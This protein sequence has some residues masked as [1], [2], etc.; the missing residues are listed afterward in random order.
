MRSSEEQT[1]LSPGDRTHPH[2]PPWEATLG[3]CPCPSPALGKGIFWF[4]LFLPC[5]LTEGFLMCSSWAGKLTNPQLIN[6]GKK[7]GSTHILRSLDTPRGR[8]PP[9]FLALPAPWCSPALQMIPLPSSRTEDARAKPWSPA[10]PH[11]AAKPR[12]DPCS[13]LPREGPGQRCPLPKPLRPQPATARPA[14]ASSPARAASWG[15]QGRREVG[16]S[17]PLLPQHF[18]V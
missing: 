2:W 18:V 14:P 11:S 12:F 6:P 16:A 15:R 7:V 9:R 8:Q 5:Y 13:Q 3:I 10:L 17:P 1:P 4:G